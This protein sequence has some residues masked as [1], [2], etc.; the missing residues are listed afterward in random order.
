VLFPGNA[1]AAGTIP[2]TH[3]YPG[4]SAP[5]NVLA[6]WMA[7]RV[8]EAGL[9]GA[10]PVMGAL[11][12]SGVQNLPA[13][14]A[15]SAGFFQMRV[16]IWDKGNYAGFP[17]QSRA[18]GEVVHRSVARGEPAASRHRPDALRRRLQPMGRV[19]GRRPPTPGAVPRPLPASVGRGGRADQWLPGR[20]PAHSSAGF[21]RACAEHPWQAPPRSGQ[22]QGDR[23][24]GVVSGRGLRG[25]GTRNACRSR[26][27]EGTQ[28]P[29]FG[30][31]DRERGK[32]Q[33]GPSARPAPTSSGQARSH[34]AR[35]AAGEDI[36][37]GSGCRGKR[38]R[39]ATRR[40]PEA[41]GLR[42]T[43]S[44]GRRRR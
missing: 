14:D 28:D 24:R 4:D 7:E 40:N 21:D 3:G 27:S 19:G 26:R 8:G 23:R 44:S 11:V 12:E 25:E 6:L 5:K 20:L 1:A 15:D 2:C 38:H 9:P 34:N 32:S 31:A 35:A 22:A 18:S 16:S 10:L 37:N 29:V 30:E 13:G 33:A 17:G 39:R 36:R 42:P 43:G 41:Q